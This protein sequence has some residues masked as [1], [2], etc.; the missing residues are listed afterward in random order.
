[1]AFWRKFGAEI[2]VPILSCLVM[3]VPAVQGPRKPGCIWLI[4]R[5]QLHLV[6]YRPDLEGVDP[7]AVPGWAEHHASPSGTVGLDLMRNLI[8]SRV[9]S[10]TRC[11]PRE[12]RSRLPAARLRRG[13]EGTIPKNGLP[14]LEFAELFLA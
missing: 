4:R 6:A 5:C 14:R 10:A 1:M 11:W 8:R 2:F 13:C 12:V 9:C 7:T 3:S